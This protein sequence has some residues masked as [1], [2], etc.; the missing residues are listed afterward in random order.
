M[1]S[2]DNKENKIFPIEQVTI[3]KYYHPYVLLVKEW[4]EIIQFKVTDRSLLYTK[5]NFPIFMEASREEAF[6]VKPFVQ[7][8]PKLPR[9]FQFW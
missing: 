3:F 4:T 8:L 1:H 7:S 6:T 5:L 2:N 9:S